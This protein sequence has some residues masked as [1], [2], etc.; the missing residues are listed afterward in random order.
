MRAWTK[1][2]LMPFA[3]MQNRHV[4]ISLYDTK[5]VPDSIYQ[6][7]LSVLGRDVL[8]DLVGVLGYYAFI[9]MTIN[10]FEVDADGENE[11]S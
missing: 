5:Q 2:S 6:R 10:V 8:V 9:S 11:L 3:K 7:A 4:A 1:K